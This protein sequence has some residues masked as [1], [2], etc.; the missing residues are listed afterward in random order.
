MMSTIV[1]L[2]LW[3]AVFSLA[4][5][6]AVVFFSLDHQKHVHAFFL[7]PLPGRRGAKF[8][9]LGMMSCE[10]WT[11]ESLMCHQK[12]AASKVPLLLASRYR[13]CGPKEGVAGAGLDV[14]LL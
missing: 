11:P 5:R 6:N 13:S 7:F 2:I 10:P 9:H 14:I 1:I 3:K 4:S 12:N 8:L